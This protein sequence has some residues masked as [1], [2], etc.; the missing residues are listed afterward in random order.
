MEAE[1]KY[2]KLIDC[3]KEQGRVAVAFSAGADSTLL[4]YAAVEALGE[5]ALAVTAKSPSVPDS[6]VAEAAETAREFGARHIIIETREFDSP[7]FR[8][9][10]RNRCYLCKSELFR[11]IKEAAGEGYKIA[12]GSNM[13]DLGDYRPGLAAGAEAGVLSPLRTAGLTKAEIREISRKLGLKT[14]DKPAYACLGSRFQYGEEM[15]DLALSQIARAEAFLREKGVK[16]ARVR[17]HAGK[18]GRN[19]IARL[20]LDKDG[21][22]LLQNE[23]GRR[24][25]GE[26]FKEIGFAYAAADILGYRAGSGNENLAE[27]D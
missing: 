8:H 3:L 25:I 24:E 13:D 27:V 1:T 20:E 19:P 21:F 15:T 16:Q 11:R 10:P 17:Y 12:E 18:D 14:W 6:E 23:E 9:N 2:G 4:L 5:G 26:K 7:E 22:A